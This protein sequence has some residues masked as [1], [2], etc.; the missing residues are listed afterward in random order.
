MGLSGVGPRRGCVQD[1]WRTKWRGVAR[2][3]HTQ[4]GMALEGMRAM[5]ELRDMCQ[6]TSM[7]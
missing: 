1:S 7:G 5:S 2:E 3:R 4:A 6:S